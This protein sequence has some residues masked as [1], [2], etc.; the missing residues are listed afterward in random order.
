MT[1]KNNKKTGF[2]LIELLIVVMLIGVLSGVLLGV[3]NV[4]GIRAKSRDAT[5]KS[6]LE[7]IRVAL[8]LYFAE[9]RVYP[10]SIWGTVL[11]T[12]ANPLTGGTIKYIS[13]LPSD[14]SVSGGATNPCASATNRDY[15]YRGTSSAYIIATNMEIPT[16][17][18]TSKCNSLSN[19]STLTCG[20]IPLDTDGA[21]RCY[22]LQNPF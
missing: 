11:S 22:G 16:S 2:T 10:F 7:K 18:D 8:E 13:K 6:D 20:A 9:N 1:F 3:V 15:W 21:D 4:A 17:D 5:R 14:P 19:W 12:L